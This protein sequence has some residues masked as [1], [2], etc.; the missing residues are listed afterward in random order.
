MNKDAITG[1]AQQPCSYLDL[2]KQLYK[3]K[4]NRKPKSFVIVS[5]ENCLCVSICMYVYFLLP[6]SLVSSVT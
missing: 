3:T 5:C 6:T 4:S 2:R 1:K